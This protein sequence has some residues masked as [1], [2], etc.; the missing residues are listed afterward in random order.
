M[1]NL[2]LIALLT[3]TA[4]SLNSFAGLPPMPR[5]PGITP[6]SPIDTDKIIAQIKNEKHATPDKKQGADFFEKQLL[7]NLMTQLQRED[8]VRSLDD[9][10]LDDVL[11]FS[12][13]ALQAWNPELKEA[14]IKTQLAKNIVQFGFMKG[15]VSPM[16]ALIDLSYATGKPQF[17]NL[18]NVMMAEIS[19]SVAGGFEKNY[20]LP[21]SINGM[22]FAQLS[23][24]GRDYMWKVLVLQ[25][26][27]DL[28]NDFAKASFQADQDINKRIDP[29]SYS[30][31]GMDHFVEQT[32]KS[33]NSYLQKY[34]ALIGYNSNFSEQGS[35][36]A[37]AKTKNAETIFAKRGIFTNALASESNTCL[38]KC[39]DVIGEKVTKY[40]DE[41]DTVGTLVGAAVGK[42]KKTGAVAA[43]GIG[44]LIGRGLGSIIGAGVGG[45]ECTK[46]KECAG[47]DEE[48]EKIA[49]EKEQKEKELKEQK[50]REQKDKQLREKAIKEQ[51]EKVQKEI[52]ENRKQQEEIKKQQEEIKRQQEKYKDDL[53]K[54]EELKK[55]KQDLEK[56]QAELKK[57][58]EELRKKE[59]KQKKDEEEERKDTEQ[60]QN[61]QQNL[62]EQKTMLK[63]DEGSG[64]TFEEQQQMKKVAS[65]TPIT[66]TDD[67]S[68]IGVGVSQLDYIKAVKKEQNSSVETHPVLV[69]PKSPNSED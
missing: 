35:L 18:I 65:S 68:I 32:M 63:E 51:K 9:K 64:M 14:A 31:R 16:M 44:G 40:G 52:D 49:K 13:L 1:K 20:N 41:G 25:V 54:Q 46:T 34:F 61:K 17:G 21:V 57:R 8:L 24:F 62:Q 11:S 43:A 33:K 67:F 15:F 69:Y 66:P 47:V 27:A 22:T 10:S 30:D 19:P 23:S 36:S 45:Y 3:L 4:V 12:A 60:K 48:K 7:Q 55:Q 28:Q 26:G 56:Q 37:E 29:M 50:D 59:E 42:V 53:K 5:G 39:M 58:E 38:S 6:V 2:Q